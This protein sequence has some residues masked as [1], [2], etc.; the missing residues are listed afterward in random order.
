MKIAVVSHSP[1][2]Y[3]AERMLM[4]LMALDLPYEMQVL[5]PVPEGEEMSRE[6]QQQGYVYTTMPS[7]GWYIYYS[8]SNQ[9]NFGG[10]CEKTKQDSLRYKE[11]FQQ[12]QPECIVINTLTNIAPYIAANELNIPVITWVHG[13]LE[14]EY[15]PNIA[16]VNYQRKIDELLLGASHGII[17]N[18]QFSKDYWCKRINHHNYIK[19]PNWF[20]NQSHDEEI[21]DSDICDF[22]CLNNFNPIKGNGL[23]L[24][25]AEVLLKKT[26]SFKIH[27][28]ADDPEWEGQRIQNEIYAKGLN[29]FVNIHPRQNSIETIYRQCTGLLQPSNYESF[30]N[31]IIEAMSYGRPVITTDKADPEHIVCHEKNGFIVPTKDAVAMSDAMYKLIEDKKLRKTMAKKAQ[32]CYRETYNGDFAKG[33]LV[34]FIDAIEKSACQKECLQE[35][36]AMHRI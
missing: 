31:T 1:Y 19:I 21:Q 35:L 9:W 26:K 34:T 2:L 25:V 5:V 16:D 17:Y 22:V 20:I 33:Q 28:Y 8:P 29:E 3:G 27:I 18:S 36:K 30:G 24:E 13:V 14:P 23:L 7:N 32:Q 11:F 6:C 4:N 15:V 10:F 12:W